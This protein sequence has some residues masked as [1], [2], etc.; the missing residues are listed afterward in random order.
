MWYP[1]FSLYFLSCRATIPSLSGTGTAFVENN[2]SM[3]TGMEGMVSG[4]S[5]CITFTVHFLSSLMLP[6]IWQEVLICS[7]KVGIPDGGNSYIQ[8][9]WS[10]DPIKAGNL[11]FV[12]I[13]IF[14]IFTEFFFNYKSQ[15]IFPFHVSKVSLFVSNEQLTDW[16]SAWL[17]NKFINT[18]L[19]QWSKRLKNFP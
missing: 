13:S 19:G 6:L 18:H 4:W 1:E 15:F 14:L 7:L 8:R 2:F 11:A 17:N 3:D 9:N 12:Y 16:K 5:K 10:W